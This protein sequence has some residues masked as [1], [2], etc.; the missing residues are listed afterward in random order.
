MVIVNRALIPDDEIARMTGKAPVVYDDMQESSLLNEIDEYAKV[1]EGITKGHWGESRNQNPFSRRDKERLFELQEKLNQSLFDPMAKIEEAR[2]EIAKI[3]EKFFPK[4]EDKK[5]GDNDDDDDGGD[6]KPGFGGGGSGGDGGGEDFGGGGLSLC[7][8]KAGEKYSVNEFDEQFSDTGCCVA[9]ED[10][11]VDFYS[12]YESSRD[13]PRVTG[14]QRFHKR[15]GGW[16][17]DW[18]L[19]FESIG[20]FCEWWGECRDEDYVIPSKDGI[21]KDTPECNS[22]DTSNTEIE[23]TKRIPD[24]NE[25]CCGVN[26][27]IWELL[28]GDKFPMQMPKNITVDPDNPTEGVEII[29]DYAD[30]FAYRFDIDDERFGQ[31]QIPIEI[32][33]IDP[34]TEGNQ[35]EKVKLANLSEAIA[36]MFGLL[37]LLLGSATVNEKLST[38]NLLETGLTRLAALR[39]GRN[40]EELIEYLGYECKESTEKV[41][42]NFD[43]D[44]ETFDELLKGTEQKIK[45]IENKEKRTLAQDLLDFKEGLKLLR[46]VFG[47]EVNPYNAEHDLLEMISNKWKH[48][49]DIDKMLKDNKEKVEE[50]LKEKFPDLEIESE[51]ITDQDRLKGF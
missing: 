36:E 33:D 34:T 30:A 9:E 44:G 4:D 1:A 48:F 5:P 40:I 6:K 16:R 10:A 31:F 23:T 2:D 42:I 41:R 39:S 25:E 19:L 27:R 28:G 45:Y 20:E 18:G 8:I 35:T 17:D 37:Y 7:T 12:H 24:M 22:Q 11:V 47:T 38:H 50:E 26:R 43:P 29:N 15:E 14:S 51:F 49:D 32:T 21:P 46:T 13:N 3:I